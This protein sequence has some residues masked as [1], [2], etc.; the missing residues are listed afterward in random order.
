MCVNTCCNVWI[1]EIC[2]FDKSQRTACIEGSLISVMRQFS[3]KQQQNVNTGCFF[4]KQY[5]H[6]N[7]GRWIHFRPGISWRPLPLLPWS[8]HWCP[9]ECFKQTWRFSN[10]PIFQSALCLNDLALP[11]MDVQAFTYDN[12]LFRQNTMLT[13]VYRFQYTK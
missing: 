1:V 10:F 13:K 6:N 5:S 7:I 8:W 4:E 9:F 11:K 12:T 2:R 3:W